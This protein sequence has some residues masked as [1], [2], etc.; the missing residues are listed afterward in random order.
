MATDTKAT[1]GA[2]PRRGVPGLQSEFG[3][4]NILSP[5]GHEVVE[6]GVGE[7]AGLKGD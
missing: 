7:A 6:Q 5:H 2:L 3:Y 1:Q 4:S